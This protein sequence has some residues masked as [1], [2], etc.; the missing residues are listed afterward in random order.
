MS[1]DVVSFGET[2]LRLS[3]PPGERLES[4]QVLRSFVAGTESNTLACLSRLGLR[5]AWSSALPD[6]PVGR[7]VAAE[8]AGHGVDTQYVHWSGGAS[9]L[10]LFYAEELAPPLG[11][12]AY[13]DRQHSACAQID[14]DAL[15]L[16]LVDGA[17]VL[18]LTGITYA[19]SSSAR[20]V[21]DRLRGRALDAGAALSFDINYRAKLWRAEEAVVGV[22]EACRSA[23]L[24]F[25]TRDDA[26][27]LWGLRGAPE[28]ILE[29]L[30]G[31]FGMEC[32]DG[33]IVVLTLGSEGA[34][35][36]SNGE[37]SHAPVYPSHGVVRFG[38]GDAFS[39]GY[40]YAHLGG[41]LFQLARDELE[42]TPLMFGNAL[43]ALKRCIP[44]D[45]AVVTP[46]EVLSVL[47]ASADRF[48]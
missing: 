43:A 28:A 19:L 3:P 9:R 4:S 36:L 18:H 17:R 39:A 6:N 13:Y 33:R 20:N 30:A 5:C 2:M 41:P 34:A 14:P 29:S 7:R 27:E 48:R 22:E 24:V 38:S 10:G 44:G 21:A 12:R 47:R 11:V 40:L 15:E 35:Q 37:Y 26:A 31:R 42:V 1:Y 23:A 16:S 8:L 25:C 45:I 46:D 32:G